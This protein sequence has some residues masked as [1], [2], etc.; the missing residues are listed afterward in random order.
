MWFKR[1]FLFLARAAIFFFLR[2]GTIFPILVKGH[3]RNISV[4][5]SEIG[6][7]AWEMLF[8]GFSIFSSV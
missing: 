6:P 3:E 7:L 5:S 4:N 2:S 8:K 1:G